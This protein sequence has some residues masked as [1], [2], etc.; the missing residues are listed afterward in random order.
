ME[1]L[2]AAFKNPSILD[3][4][5]G[6]TSVDPTESR[7]KRIK[8]LQKDL[9]S[10]TG[11]LGLRIAGM[12]RVVH[13]AAGTATES[14]HSNESF[15]ERRG[16]EW[17]RSIRQEEMQAALQRFFTMD[18]IH[19]NLAVCALFERSLVKL[20]EFQENQHEFKVISSSLLFLYESDTSELPKICLKMIDFAHVQYFD[21]EEQRNK[22]VDEEYLFGLRVLLRLVK[23]IQRTALKRS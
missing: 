16:R 13:P 21:A 22:R 20:I 5:I 3:L 2:T 4:K 1:D 12:R 10:T 18:N 23:D 19:V 7:A 17:G 11:S 9:N 15:I 8:M 6:T 14:K